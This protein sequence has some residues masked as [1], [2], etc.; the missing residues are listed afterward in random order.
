M[1][2]NFQLNVREGF[3]EKRRLFFG[4]FIS[5]ILLGAAVLFTSCSDDL[6]VSEIEI[7]PEPVLIRLRTEPPFRIKDYS[8]IYFTDSS[9]FYAAELLREALPGRYR[10]VYQKSLEGKKEGIWL[11]YN[12]DLVIKPSGYTLNIRESLVR[13]DAREASGILNGVQS[14]RQLLPT[15][16]ESGMKTALQ[17]AEITDFPRFDWRGMHLD[18]SRHFMP[19]D[20]VKKYIDMLSY[21]KLN[22]FHWHLTDGVGWRIEIKSHPELTD[23]GAWR[24][25]KAGKRPWEDFEVWREGDEEPRY[26]GY[27]TQEEI[28]EIVDYAARR[29]ITVVPEIELPGHSEAVLQCYPGLQCVDDQ[30]DYLPNIG[31]YCASQKATYSFLED[32]LLEVME[33]FPSKYIHIGGDE[34]NKSNWLNCSRDLAF[35]REHHFTA[36][37]VQSYFVNH[38]DRFLR[39]HGR[40]MIGWHEILDGDLS[41]S[42]TVMYWGGEKGVEEMF[43][44]GHDAVLTTGSHYY[45]D[46]YQ[47]ASEYEPL[48]F[49]GLST[50]TGVYHYEPFPDSLEARYKDQMLGIQ[51]NIWTEYK[52]NPEQVEYAVFPRIAALA[53]TAWTPAKNKNWEKFARKI[54]RLT[55]YYETQNIRFSKSAYRPMIDVEVNVEKGGLDVVLEPELMSELFYTLDGRLPD[56]Q[57]STRYEGPF[58]VEKTLTVTAGAFRNDTL[59][60]E[61]EKR[62]MIIHKALGKI[63]ELSPAN[64]YPSYS[65]GGANSLV[66]GRFGGDNWGNNRWLGYLNEDF[67]ATIRFPEMT[68]I[69]SVGYSAIEDKP[70]GIHFPENIQIR[71]AG[72]DGTERELTTLDIDPTEIRYDTKTK[73]SVFYLDFPPVKTKSVKVKAL[74]PRVPDQGVFLFIDEIIVQ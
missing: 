42:A 26:G 29:N 62:E 44:K 73:D 49:G 67:S 53:E 48:S 17:P 55:D 37:E 7:I 23:I 31:V 56:P 25:I 63:V 15:E 35:M 8:E 9:M 74:Y 60:T 61:A 21:H 46:H 47:S 1:N 43:S 65:Y 5:G 39:E 28:R 30:G 52:E 57:E 64:P 3:R 19:P 32:I 68:E 45:F 40:K 34:V 4:K 66:D 13:I 18:V 6:Q 12:P 41:P 36:E 51:A 33:L 70:S 16:P 22:V 14:L 69:Q 20:F 10:T 24:K 38:F 50:L 2:V 58:H 72:E 27:Y 11:V 59:I 71:V 54:P